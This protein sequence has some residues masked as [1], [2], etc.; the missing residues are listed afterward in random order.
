MSNF[1]EDA[2][3]V[4]NVSLS[5]DSFLQSVS[6]FNFY[7]FREQVRHIL[8]CEIYMSVV[9]HG[10]TVKCVDTEIVCCRTILPCLWSP[11]LH[12]SLSSTG[13]SY[14]S[15]AAMSCPLF[16]RIPL[17]VLVLPAPPLL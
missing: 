3:C 17:L 11:M 10:I 15:F 6:V 1:S 5:D 13:L 4:D 2:L 7:Q 12:R 8:F 14:Q 16:L 9:Y